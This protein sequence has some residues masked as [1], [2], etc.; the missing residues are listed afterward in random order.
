MPSN[1]LIMAGSYPEDVIMRD[2]DDDSLIHSTSP[3]ASP[4]TGVFEFS[5]PP[6][7]NNG[8]LAGSIGVPHGSPANILSQPP[9]TFS[10]I[11]SDI[12]LEET[13]WE[14]E[15]PLAAPA[16][17]L[18]L[19]RQ[20]QPPRT[21][22]PTL[23]EIG[24]EDTPWQ[25]E[26]PWGAPANGARTIYPPNFPRA[27]RNLI[28][29]VPLQRPSPL[30]RNF[31]PLII[32]VFGASCTDFQLN[33][34]G[35]L[36]SL[37]SQRLLKDI[38]IILAG[39]VRECWDSFENEEMILEE[40]ALLQAGQARYWAHVR[41]WLERLDDD[42][43]EGAMSWNGMTGEKLWHLL[44]AHVSVISR[45][46]TGE[47]IAI[48]AEMCPELSGASQGTRTLEGVKAFVAN[49]PVVGRE[50]IKVARVLDRSCCICLEEYYQM[51]ADGEEVENDKPLR[52]GCGHV[53]GS[54]CLEIL[55]GPKD[56]ADME[57]DSCPL[58]RAKVEFGDYVKSSV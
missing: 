22:S 21:L 38:A 57:V 18:S 6:Y 17:L 25:P 30:G 50:E 46:N 32:S 27:L 33:C 39:V 19:S 11:L 44:S 3:E 14:P 28:S 58:C 55:F 5:L 29:L 26:P 9:R 43:V 54:D 51:S 4:R 47:R 34:I 2:A 12:G 1:E 42:V 20:E 13:P 35:N 56:W 24:L 36:L 15:T 52:L 41:H 49:L 53:V 45:P 31:K 16:N 10:Q 48:R 7:I 40:V 23:S 8:S 37:A